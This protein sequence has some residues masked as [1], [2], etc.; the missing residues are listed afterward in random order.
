MTDRNLP[1]RETPLKTESLRTTGSLRRTESLDRAL[2]GDAVRVGTEN[3]AKCEAVRIALAALLGAGDVLS[4]QALSI[5]P[6]AVASGVP[7]QPVGYEEIIAGARQ[8]ARAAFSSGP[9]ALAVGIED[10]LVRLPDGLI[11]STSSSPS[12]GR[13]GA[14]SAD[15]LG[16]YNVGCAWV[17]DGTREAAGFSSGFAYPP[18][19]AGPA[20]EH[21][22]PIGDLFDAL[23]RARRN[24]EDTGP[25]G[26][27]EGNIGKLTA[28]RLPRSDYGSHAILCALVRF[29]HKDLYD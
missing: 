5:L 25:S 27:R 16:V 13:A 23:W 28:G 4:A 22:E 11:P 15:A 26:P 19:C 12:K 10:G 6:V 9:C 17:S 2:A 29:L 1:A 20:I 14:E 7:E 8:R 21:G 18:A 24:A 3:R